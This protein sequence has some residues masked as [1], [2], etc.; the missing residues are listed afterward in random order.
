MDGVIKILTFRTDRIGDL[1]NTSPFLKSLK[2]H[3]SNSE[4]HLV[5]SKYNSQ[6]AKN[7]KFIDKIFII[8]KQ[9]NLINKI[10]FFFKII[11]NHYDICIVIDGKTIS[12][13]ISFFIRAKHKYIVCFKKDKRLF[14]FKKT[15]Y[16]PPIFICK[17]FYNTHVLCDESY[18]KK[19]VNEEF[20]NHYLSM[21]Y[22]LLK[23]N[24]VN[25]VPCKHQFTLEESSKNL[26]NSFFK[27]FIKSKYINLHVDYKWDSYDININDFIAILKKISLK[28]KIVISSGKEGSNFFNELKKHF[29]V[30]TFQN[31]DS[32]SVNN[33]QSQNVLLIEKLSVNLLACFLEKS[34][35]HVSSHSGATIHISAAFN[36]P[37]I[38]FI[39]K[40]KATE[41]DRWIPN[42]IRYNRVFINNLYE[43]KD[44]I[45]KNI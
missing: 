5:C 44:S 45:L 19:N 29:F 7:Y 12:K 31:S 1:I 43:L 13:L 22:F 16:R 33:F 15:V 17:K 4:I 25:L 38:D 6:I 18:D 32:P 9:D 40:S 14:G 2:N 10:K 41:Y 24:Y 37:I 8:D 42:G 3:Y 20:S 21:Y 23:K 35:L 30:I 11:F 27:E 28:S 34:L 26:F 39:E 36:I